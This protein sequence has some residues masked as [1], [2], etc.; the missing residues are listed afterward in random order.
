[1][2]AGKIRKCIVAGQNREKRVSVTK[3]FLPLSAAITKESVFAIHARH[4][5][6]PPTRGSMCQSPI[7]L[8]TELGTTPVT[9]FRIVPFPN[10]NHIDTH[11]STFFISYVKAASQMQCSMRSS[12]VLDRIVRAKTNPLWNRTVLL[13]LLGQDTLRTESLVRWLLT[14]T[15]NELARVQ[16]M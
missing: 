4:P 12:F 6:H 7:C 9:T 1:M 3:E 10:H 2:S 8:Q 14:H 13:G 5:E 15:Y 16:C 11:V